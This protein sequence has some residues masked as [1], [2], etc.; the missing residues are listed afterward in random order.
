VIKPGRVVVSAPQLPDATAVIER[1]A[2]ERR[3][4]LQIAGQ[5]GARWDAAPHEWDLLTT[6]GRLANLRI[7]LRGSHQRTNAAVAATI[8]VALDEAGIGP[9]SLD[10]IRVG[11]E[12]AA[13]PGRFEIVP[14]T[15]PIVID[16]AHNVAA[17][18][19][20][21]LTLTQE[22]PSARRLFVFGVAADKDLPHILDELLHP[23]PSGAIIPRQAESFLN[24][25]AAPGPLPVLI[26][27]R[28]DHP[29]ATDP[30]QIAPL[31]AALGV[32]CHV[33]P[34]VATGLEL[35]RE[36]AQPD[37][38]IVA[39]GS[40]YVVAEAREA[41]GLATETDHTPFNPWAGR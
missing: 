8:L 26:A 28:A 20:L 11:I 36:L 25:A 14:G 12:Q 18:R 19:A 10:A 31:A 21:S 30:A 35:A 27:T 9:I 34:T 3:A 15:P 6:H 40:L 37:D 7:G 1:T 39:A 5:N 32:P 4:I 17:A 29:R 22:Y 2:Q 16:G 38:V 41:L 24:Q 33:T 13:W 23:A